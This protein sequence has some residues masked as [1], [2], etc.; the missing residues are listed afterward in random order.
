MLTIT[1][2][3]EIDAGHRLVN[4][5]SKCKNVHGH[6]YVFEVEV[7]GELDQVGRVI[8]YGVIKSTLGGWL[9]SHWDHGFI[10]EDGDP[11]VETLLRYGMK[12]FVLN[13]PPT[14]ENIAKYFFGIASGLMQ[15]SGITVVSVTVHE[16][17]NC[18][19]I[20]NGPPA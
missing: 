11:L 2:R 10:A 15:Q 14:A 16:T 20:Y 12:V 17:P 3:L 5:E 8:D 6:R 9:D 19:A 13:A 7:R 1:R 4:H 18:K